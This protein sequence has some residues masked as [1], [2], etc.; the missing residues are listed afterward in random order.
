MNAHRT[1]AIIVG[2]LFIIGTAAG[3]TSAA[4]MGSFLG[5]S[6][7]L[8][9]VSANS[10][11]VMAGAFFVL[12]MALSLAMIPVVLFPIL[13]KRNEAL[14]IGYVVFRGALETMITIAQVVCLFVLIIL[15]QKFAGAGASGASYFQ[16]LGALLLGGHANLTA[17]LSIVFPIGALM[18]YYVLYKER[19][20]PR[21]LSGWGFIAAILYLV[22]G[23][24]DLF[25]S[26]MVILLLPMLVQEMV[27]AVWLIVKGFNTSEIADPV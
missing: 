8:S 20:I 16:T 3:M 9:K 25:S 14:A 27:M 22:G 21:W 1:A 17:I 2:I 5:A 4:L 19:L 23:L 7:Y 10:G 24:H 15:S 6:D 13:K 11:L 18:F 12:I 26:E